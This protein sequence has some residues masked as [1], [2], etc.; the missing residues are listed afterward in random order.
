LEISATEIFV[1][2]FFSGL[3]FTFAVSPVLI[4]LSPARDKPGLIPGIVEWH[5]WRPWIILALVLVYAVGIAGN[6][7]AEE[8]YALIGLDVNRG[9]KLAEWQIRIH[10]ETMRDWV[11]RH[12]SY[13][14]ILRAGSL[15]CIL[16]LICMPIYRWRA[17]KQ[18]DR[19]TWKHYAGAVVMLALFGSALLLE[20][21]HYEK[22]LCTRAGAEVR[23][24][25]DA[26]QRCRDLGAAKSAR[27]ETR[28]PAAR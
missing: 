25:A 14:K 8:L 11:E 15:S 13:M 9:L 6:R 2:I 10:D 20:R 27:D 3:L 16:F 17:Q 23:L 4:L 28:Q 22:D 24:D 19:Y 12:K 1:E 5:E 21:G 7:L 18:R 26:T